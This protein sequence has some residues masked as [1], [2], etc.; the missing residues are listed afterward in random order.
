MKKI[1]CGSS[2]A[3][4]IMLPFTG[5]GQTPAPGKTA[6]PR[7]STASTSSAASLSP[8]KNM[9]QNA[10]QDLKQRLT[11]EQYRVTQQSGTEPPFHNAYWNN[12]ADGIYVD[13]VSGEPLFSS[14]DKY[15]SG[16]GWPSFTKPIQAD[17][18]KVQKDTSHG[19]VRDEVKAEKSNSHL[20][21]VFDDGPQDKGGLRYCMNSASLRFIPIDKLKEE[22][23]GGYLKLFEKEKK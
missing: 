6:V 4:A 11:P 19:M 13:V 16:C 5:W 15:D 8:V 21:H 17:V 10:H 9:S 22:G 12:H 18:V 14:K 7:A 23:Y 2:V 20:G 1:S 3:F